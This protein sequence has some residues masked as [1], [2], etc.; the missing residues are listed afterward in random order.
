MEL[1][2]QTTIGT[3]KEKDL[4]PSPLEIKITNVLLEIYFIFGVKNHLLPKDNPLL[5]N[6]FLENL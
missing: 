6:P 3:H 2:T 5:D 4:A 1:Y